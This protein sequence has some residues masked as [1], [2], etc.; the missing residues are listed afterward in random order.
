MKNI[1]D[2]E[3]KLVNILNKTKLTLHNEHE[4][5]FGKTKQNSEIL[6]FDG[7]LSMNTEKL[8]NEY[9]SVNFSDISLMK[10]ENMHNDM[11]IILKMI[12][13]QKS[14][15]N[16]SLSPS[17]NTLSSLHYPKENGINIIDI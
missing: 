2:Y 17:T 13:A 12:E 10:F 4:G 9:F 14:Q 15:M 7:L 11:K 3:N 8:Y 16:Y 1:S 5:D 6:I